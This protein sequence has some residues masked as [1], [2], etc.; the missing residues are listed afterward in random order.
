[1]TEQKIERV[2]EI[3]LILYWLKVMRIAES[4]DSIWSPHGN[5]LGLSYGKLAILFITY[6]IHSLNHRLSGMEEWVIKHKT[7]LEKVTGWDIG[8]KDATDDRLGIMIGDIGANA[9]NCLEFQRQI[10][11]HLIQ[12]FELPTSIGR[13]DTTSVNV[14]H[15]PENNKNELLSFGHSK[16]NRP[17]LLQFKQGLG[18]LDPAGIPI[19]TETLAGKEA[20]DPLYVPAWREMSKTLGKTEFLFVTDCKGSVLE[21]RATIDKENG[22]YLC[23]LAMTGKIPEEL[24]KLVFNPPVKPIDIKFE[25]KVDKEGN[26]V[27]VG[28][29]LV[30]NKDMEIEKEGLKHNWKEQW[31]VVQSY[32]HAARQKKAINERVKKATQA[33]TKLKPKTDEDFEHF[34][35]R[36]SRIVKK[37]SCESILKIQ[38]KEVVSQQ[39][40]YTKRGRPTSNT[41]YELI[42]IRRLELN[43]KVNQEELEENLKIAGWRIYVANT[44]SETM[45]LEQSVRY[46][47][48]E[49]LVERS[50]HRFK[51]GKLPVLP[52]FLRLP[53]R[54]KGLMLLLVVAL[55]VFTLMEF[56]IRRELAKQEE[57]LGGLVPGNPSIKTARPTSERIISKFNNLHIIIINTGK[58]IKGHLV[59]ALTPLQQR[60][61]ELL[62]I[63]LDIYEGLSFNQLVLS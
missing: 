24:K 48:D 49:W 57:T 62:R 26:P 61:L 37:Y 27:V 46:Y 43:F 4:I 59:E 41:P 38:I 22:S 56:V 1:M 17:D 18:V 52:L 55:Q 63:P 34:H 3:P 60:I 35:E 51:K 30:I 11:K 7:V 53:E 12:A 16:D 2:D 58:H 9:S 36:A 23:P 19:F 29:G 8:E 14:H 40:R 21:N 33:I 44:T 47:R 13:Y 10:G 39:K 54:I 50:F 42:E 6:V 28:Q 31:F 15:S 45:T 20:D 32:A 25:E 5:W